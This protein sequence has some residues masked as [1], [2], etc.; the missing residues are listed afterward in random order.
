M[1]E[2]DEYQYFNER[3]SNPLEGTTKI[4]DETGN[5]TTNFLGQFTSNDAYHSKKYS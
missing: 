2:Q 5:T 4:N 1:D 3:E